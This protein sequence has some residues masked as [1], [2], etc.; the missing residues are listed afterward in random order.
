MA[1]EEDNIDTTTV[2][3]V[4]VISAG[5]TFAL[6]FL[7]M[8]LYHSFDNAQVAIEQ[9]QPHL[10]AERLL[11]QQAAILNEAAWVDENNNQV[12]IPVSTAMELVV[13]QLAKTPNDAGTNPPQFAE[14]DATIIDPSN[15]TP[16][17][18]SE[19]AESKAP[20]G[21]EG[22]PESAEPASPEPKPEPKP[23]SKPESKPEPAE[24][25]A[26]SKETEEA[27]K[28]TAESKPAEKTEEKPAAETTESTP[29]EG[30]TEKPAPAE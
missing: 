1:H 13:S 12:R 4:G 11:D 17:K 26:P 22:K 3:V 8:V 18:K 24:K 29:E 23:E 21:E 19:S 9:K 6:I 20:E 16:P 14:A 10:E 25:P 30:T 27:D 15:P 5:L 7:L 2:A 28:P